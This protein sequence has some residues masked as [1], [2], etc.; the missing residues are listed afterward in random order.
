M[1]ST[2]YLTA[3]L[4]LTA[5]LAGA[6]EQHMRNLVYRTPVSEWR[7]LE[8]DVQHILKRDAGRSVGGALRATEDA[9]RCR[10]R[11]GEVEVIQGEVLHSMLRYLSPDSLGNLTYTSPTHRRRTL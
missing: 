10:S 2:A 1:L 6:S 11:R 4:A 9:E 8:H 7:E 5:G 3:A